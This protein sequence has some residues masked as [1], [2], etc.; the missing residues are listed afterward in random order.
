MNVLHFYTV[1]GLPI[2]WIALTICCMMDYS[3]RRG[4]LRRMGPP[5]E[6]EQQMLERL[7]TEWPRKEKKP[8]PW[9]FQHPQEILKHGWYVIPLLVVFWPMVG[10]M[11]MLPK[12]EIR[13]SPEKIVK[14]N[15][16]WEREGRGASQ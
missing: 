14:L 6:E 7:K 13:L 9:Y 1:I 4:E 16:T 5:T 15:A 2:W 12:L 3:Q 11:L 8:L 10:L